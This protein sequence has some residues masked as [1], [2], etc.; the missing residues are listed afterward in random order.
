MAQPGLLLAFQFRDNALGQRLAQFDTPLVERV[1][2]PDGP[3]G[4]DAMLVESHEFAQGLRRKARG[5][6]RVGGAVALEDAVGHKPIRRALGLHLF[7][8]LTEG[9]RFGLGK[10]IGQEYV[11]V[12][13]QGVERLDEGNEV[14]RDESG[15]LMN[16]L[17][18]GVLAVGPRLAPIDGAGLVRRLRSR[19]G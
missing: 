9:Q 13:A 7:R 8:R 11:M 14:A 16:Q 5:Y 12:P 6:D 3:L 2:I 1:D 10:D 18:E 4:K 17:V 15:S 19:P